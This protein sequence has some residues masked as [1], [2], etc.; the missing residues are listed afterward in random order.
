MIHRINLDIKTG[1]QEYYVIPGGGVENNEKIED[2]VIREM[3]EETNLDV[4]LGELFYELED[5]DQ[6]GANIK[7]CAY[8]CEYTGGE[9]KLREDSEEAKE[10]KDGINFFNPVWVDLSE[11]KNIALFP[12]PL[13]DKLI[14]NF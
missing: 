13:K 12:S 5:L 2:A 10:M 7:Y 6:Q 8:L 14:Q 11:I 9:P 1:T 3:K 4:K